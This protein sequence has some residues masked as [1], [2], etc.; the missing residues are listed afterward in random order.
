ML[1]GSWALEVAAAA[2]RVSVEAV[3]VC[4]ALVRG[5]RTSE[6]VGWLRD[7]GAACYEIGEKLCRRLVDREGPDGVAAVARM[8][9]PALADVTVPERATVLVADGLQ[10]AGN[11]GTVVRCAD[12]AGAVAVL[13]TERRVRL[14]PPLVVKAS[15][16]AVFH[17]PVV[18]VSRE[19]AR[20]WIRR[21][22][23]DVVAADPAGP[24]AYRAAVTAGG[25]RPRQ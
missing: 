22:G 6:I 25:H 4:P 14:G 24:V 2:P 23:L 8:S 11:L 10:L 15:M 7:R 20:T 3:F 1:E 19:D 16:G 5:S 18:E 17:L 12:G 13:V 9:W 21:H